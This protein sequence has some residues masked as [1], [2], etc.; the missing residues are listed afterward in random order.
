VTRKSAG[1]PRQRR[2][3]IDQHIS[4]YIHSLQAGSS[5]ALEFKVVGL[6]VS[7]ADIQ[8]DT[9]GTADKRK[10]VTPQLTILGIQITPCQSKIIIDTVG[11]VLMLVLIGL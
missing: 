2:L 1:D 8:K 5:H 10:G 11:S 3:A 7:E 6:N 4:G 9:L